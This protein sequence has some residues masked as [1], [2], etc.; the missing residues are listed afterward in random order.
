MEYIKVT[1]KDEIY[2]KKLLQIKDYPKELYVAGNHKLLNQK[3]VVA[4]IGSRDCTEYGR[5]YASYFS[6]ELSKKGICIVSGMAIGIDTSA[7]IG[8]VENEG[9][10]IAVLGGG[11][12]NIYPKQNEWLF[13]KILEN[14]GCIITEYAP[15][16]DIDKKN[17]PKRNRIVSG[18]SDALLVVEAE[19]RSGTSITAG[20]AKSQGKIVCCIPGNLENR[21]SLG[22]NRLIQQGAKLIIKP[23]EIIEILENKNLYQTTT[24]QNQNKETKQIPKECQEIYNIIKLNPL[25][26]NDICKT[27]KKEVKEIAQILTKLELEDLIEQIAGNKYKVKE[28]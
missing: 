8:A 12:N 16:V 9:R 21:C 3:Q 1:Y 11:F 2:P 22:T 5:K 23:N 7:H 28:N 13:H 10:T 18:L 24:L 14:S 20:Y 17:F 6:E 4:I 25:H 15:N 27:S 26:I 19:Y